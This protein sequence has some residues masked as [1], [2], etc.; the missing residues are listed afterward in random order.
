MS[1]R[2]GI[3]DRVLAF[4]DRPWRAIVV[5]ILVIILGIGWALWDYRAQIAEAILTRTVLPRLEIAR[6]DTIGLA[7]LKTTG[8]DA[9][10]LISGDLNKNVA[11]N[12]KGFDKDGQPWLAM[13]GARPILFND[14]PV[15]WLIRFLSGQV[16]CSN[17]IDG[18]E[19]MRAEERLGMKR[20]CV[21]PIPPFE[22]VLV[23]GLWVG[24]K[25]PPTADAEARAQYL[26]HDAAE[27]LATW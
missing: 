15:S 21:A 8:A 20:S 2:L 9:V 4:M 22:N 12:L 17:I 10:M 18:G 14:Y 5:I 25:E 1:D 26:M 7:L 6:F 23:G 24:W 11:T 3:I 19:E 13:T 16:I 27:K